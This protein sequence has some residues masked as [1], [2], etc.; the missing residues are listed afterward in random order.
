MF[1]FRI[2]VAIGPAGH[3]TK[4]QSVKRLTF[5]PGNNRPLVAFIGVSEDMKQATFTVS[6]DVSS[7][8]GGGKCIPRRGL[9]NFLELKPGEK[10]SLSYTPEGNRTYN[11]KLMGIDLAPVG[12][13]PG[14]TQGKRSSGPILGPDG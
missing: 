13:V 5:L 9:C 14:K 4:R 1:A 10:A 2:S 6:Q 7:V 3:L 11:L 12:K 8:R